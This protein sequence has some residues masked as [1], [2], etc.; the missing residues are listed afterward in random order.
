[1]LSGGFMTMWR[2]AIAIRTGEQTGQVQM[3]CWTSLWV[4]AMCCGALERLLT[5][6]VVREARH[7]LFGFRAAGCRSGR[8]HQGVLGRSDLGACSSRAA[9]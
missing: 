9:P 7:R 3:V 4:P 5:W 2:M 8:A 6:S 1:V